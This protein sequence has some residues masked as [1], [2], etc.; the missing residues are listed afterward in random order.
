VN[1]HITFSAGVATAD[2]DRASRLNLSPSEKEDVSPLLRR[3]S[4]KTKMLI[5]EQSPKK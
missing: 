3:K 1:P 5:I 4:D 2:E